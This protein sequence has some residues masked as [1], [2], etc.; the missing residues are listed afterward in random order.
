MGVTWEIKPSPVGEEY[1]DFFLLNA[2]GESLGVPY[3]IEP[4][5]LKNKEAMMET[6][7]KVADWFNLILGQ[8]APSAI[9][10]FKKLAEKHLV[11]DGTSWKL[12]I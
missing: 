1:F 3:L 5:M 8:Q 9:E 4:Y 10:E 7:Q 12:V 6:L 11:F 2:E